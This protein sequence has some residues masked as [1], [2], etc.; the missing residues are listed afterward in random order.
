MVQAA[1]GGS[2]YVAST[3]SNFNAIKQ[4]DPGSCFFWVLALSRKG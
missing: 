4:P 1:P 3:G 2:I